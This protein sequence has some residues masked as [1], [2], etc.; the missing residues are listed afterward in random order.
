MTSAAYY[1]ASSGLALPNPN[2]YLYYLDAAILLKQHGGE[3]A[4]ILSD[5]AAAEKNVPAC[6]L[7]YVASGKAREEHNDLTG[8]LSDFQTAVRLAP[9]L[10]EGWYHLA[11]VANRIGKKSEAAQARRHFQQIKANE[12]EREKEMM[13]E[14]FLQSLGEVSGAPH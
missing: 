14:V 6:A 9:G 12:D 8:A 2:P 7:C 1:V 4:Q 11:S 3:Y 10:S 5:L 13:R